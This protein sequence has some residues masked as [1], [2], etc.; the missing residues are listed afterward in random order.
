MHWNL[1]PIEEIHGLNLPP[2]EPHCLDNPTQV[3][4][5]NSLYRY[6][7]VEIPSTKFHSPCLDEFDDFMARQESFNAYVGRELKNNAFKIGRVGDNLARVKDEL[8]RVSKYDSMVATQAEQVPKAQNELLD[9]LNNKNDFAVRVATRTGKM[10]QEPLYPEGHPK[11]IEQ[12]SQNNNLDVPSSSKKK[13]KKNDRTMQTSS[14][15]NIKT[16]ENPNNTSIS[17]AET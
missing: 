3:V 1:P 15:P 16:L 2:E 11:R 9:E 14:E 12:D 7:K 10:T 4:K 17:D 5:V 6:D 13:K 8:H